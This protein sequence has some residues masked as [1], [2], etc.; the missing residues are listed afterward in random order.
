M[1]S[2]NIIHR[3]TRDRVSR[4]VWAT[5]T[6]GCLIGALLAGQQHSSTLADEVSAAQD[7][8][9]FIA[10][11]AL[12]NNL[13][14]D[15][16]TKTIPA[17]L[18]RDIIVALQTDAF[19]S[20]NIAR[21]RVWT[22]D[23]LLQFSTHER[24]QVGVLATQDPTARSL[25]AQAI[26][27]GSGSEKVTTKFS[28]ASTGDQDATQTALLEVYVPLRVPDRVSIVGAAEVD[29]Y[30]DNLVQA[31]HH[32][33]YRL[34]VILLAFAAFCLLMTL[35]SFRTPVQTLGAGVGVAAAGT[36]ADSPLDPRRS[37]RRG[38]APPSDKGT[39]SL[40]RDAELASA[41]ATKAEVDGS[42]LRRQLATSRDQLQQ[43]E[44]AYLIIETKLKQAQAAAAPPGPRDPA[45]SADHE[46][47]VAEATH[48]RELAEAA[49][50]SSKD[51]LDARESALS[52]AQAE[53]ALVRAELVAKVDEA[54]AASASAAAAAA[55]LES[56]GAKDQ[57]LAA[58]REELASLRTEL[59]RTTTDA[60]ST[61]SD[62]ERA[63]AAADATTKDA[64]AR[65]ADAEAAAEVSRSAAEEAAAALA[66]ASTPIEPPPAA[67][68]DELLSQLE[69]RMLAAETRART[70]EQGLAELRASVAAPAAE[71]DA[72]PAD[73]A[74]V[75]DLRSRLARTAA[76]KKL[77]GEEATGPLGAPDGGEPLSPPAQ[78]L[79]R[80][81]AGEIRNPIAT[82]KG[83]SLSL[84]G[85][86]STGEGKELIRQMNVTVKKL[87]QLA[88]DLVEAGGISDGS[89]PL[90]RRRTDLEALVSRVVSE[91][92]G[93][94]E[95]DVRMDL[96]PASASVDPARLQ[97]ILD[98][99]LNHA[100]ERT[101][102]SGTIRIRLTGDEDGGTI[103]VDDEGE[104]SSDVGPQLLL[105]A[106]LAELHGGR[107]WSEPRM[108][109]GG[110]SVKVFLPADPDLV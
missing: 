97:Q 28:A 19:T 79:Q 54:S 34:V 93:I 101:G 46:R 36:F 25:I 15:T 95:V 98:G 88:S 86:V 48:A 7:Q 49:L 52:A 5:L 39:K 24:D 87:D 30:Y 9:R 10:N 78:D 107:L 66:A 59:E 80:S 69:G 22:P 84:K 103:A 4:Y 51:A 100:R 104:P 27:G 65:A 106:R 3:F 17:P 72:A 13:T 81:M 33:W 41:R 70:A 14:Y 32:P 8:A 90:N 76:R 58:L 77:G 110:S 82:L 1:G 64:L 16:M 20:P 12:F 44:E 26:K 42:D 45:P 40:Q 108:G 92:D 23:G 37:G 2:L 53:V 83:L 56:A 55:A 62:A 89:L 35:L 99:V 68:D 18:Y 61:R 6:I 96:E 47:A 105:A 102:A 31:S 85:A 29:F 50:A 43:A 11:T 94:S 74:G 109:G 73:V 38:P 91:A 67:I 75:R 63:I 21:I 60:D 57:D 71:A